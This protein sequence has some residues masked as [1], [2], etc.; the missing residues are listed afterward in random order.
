MIYIDKRIG[1][2]TQICDDKTEFAKSAITAV[3]NQ[4]WTGN[5][6]KTE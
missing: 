5:F 1:K 6:I 3:G 4:N 2:Y